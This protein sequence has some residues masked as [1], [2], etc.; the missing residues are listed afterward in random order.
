MAY[1]LEIKIVNAVLLGWVNFRG[2][3]IAVYWSKLVVFLN[4]KIDVTIIISK[5][6]YQLVDDVIRNKVKQTVVVASSVDRKK[7]IVIIIYLLSL[8]VKNYRVD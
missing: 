3:L 2:H 4:Q 8:F 5:G 1:I 6:V 7:G